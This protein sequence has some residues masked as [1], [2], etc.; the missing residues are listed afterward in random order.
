MG[1]AEELGERVYLPQLL[2]LQAAIARA[3]GRAD[4]GAGSAR[5]AVEE[6]RTQQAPWLELLALVDLCAHHDAAADER[7]ALAVLLD[8]LPESADTELAT[9]ARLL[10]QPAKPA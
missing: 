9:R 4:A 8:Q 7:D 5:R 1:I 10:L 6:A 3:R 2:L